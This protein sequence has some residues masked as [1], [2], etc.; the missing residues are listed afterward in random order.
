MD[1]I[2]CKTDVQKEN[3]HESKL[4]KTF[5]L[6][7]LQMSCL[8]TFFK[9]FV[10][11]SGNCW[12]SMVLCFSKYVSKPGIQELFFFM[13][14]SLKAWEQLQKPRSAM[15]NNVLTMKGLE[16]TKKKKHHDCQAISE[17]EQSWCSR[18]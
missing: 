16:N 15:T 4:K 2:V 3:Q 14:W 8:S 6:Q 13:V 9:S 10:W 7:K 11:F 18:F 17:D 1:K 12:L 5:E